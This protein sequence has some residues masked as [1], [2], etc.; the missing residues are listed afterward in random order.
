MIKIAMIHEC[1]VYYQFKVSSIIFLKGWGKLKVD[2]K[3]NI[4]TMER[5]EV[6]P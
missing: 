5:G 6:L 3:R 2:L 1:G 4:Y